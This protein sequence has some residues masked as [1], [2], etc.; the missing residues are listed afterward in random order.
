ML[1]KKLRLGLDFLKEADKILE[2]YE[3]Q[4]PKELGRF[5]AYYQAHRECQ[6]LLPQN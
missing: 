3:T 4:D 1:K 6:G 5:E 2:H